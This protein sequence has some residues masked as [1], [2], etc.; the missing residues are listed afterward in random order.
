VR[1]LLTMMCLP[2]QGTLSQ[3][4]SQHGPQRT[5]HTTRPPRRIYRR[6]FRYLEF[7]VISALG[8]AQIGGNGYVYLRVKSLPGVSPELPFGLILDSTGLRAT[9]KGGAGPHS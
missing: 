1:V 7:C 4:S 2:P 3:H 6:G 5:Q 9:P 8:Y